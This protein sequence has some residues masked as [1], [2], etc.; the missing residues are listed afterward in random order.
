MVS[1]STMTRIESYFTLVR[2]SSDSGRSVIKSRDIDCQGLLGAS[3]GCRYPY[4][5][6]LAALLLMQRLYW[7][8]TFCTVF[9]SPGK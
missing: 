4:G 9:L 6:C 5:V 8:T 1:L 2:G 3:K 7:E